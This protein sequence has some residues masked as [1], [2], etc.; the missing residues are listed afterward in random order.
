MI[1][2]LN[3]NSNV[4]SENMSKVKVG[5]WKVVKM[6]G[7]AY[8]KI[9]ISPLLLSTYLIHSF[10]FKLATPRAINF[11]NLYYLTLNWEVSED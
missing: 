1:G 5:R 11:T 9:V 7:V 8:H 4:K 3:K 10:G 6:E 2:G